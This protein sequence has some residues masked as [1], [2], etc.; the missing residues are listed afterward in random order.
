MEVVKPEVVYDPVGAPIITK[1][2]TD[3][4]NL[5]SVSID[6]S[7]YMNR[8]DVNSKVSFK[9]AATDEEIAYAMKVWSYR[10]LHMIVDTDT[11]NAT[12]DP[13]AANTMFEVSVDGSA[14][15]IANVFRVR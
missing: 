5:Y 11:S 6:F 14:Y 10:T 8:S 7:K 13:L 12:T 3:P 4:E 1:I 15:D 2:Y 9:S